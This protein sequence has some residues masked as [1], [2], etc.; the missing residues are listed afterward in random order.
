LR[1]AGAKLLLRAAG[2]T[3]ATIDTR[4]MKVTRQ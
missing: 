1:R 4:T 3:L 2:E